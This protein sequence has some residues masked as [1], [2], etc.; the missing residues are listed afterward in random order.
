MGE[1]KMVVMLTGLY[2]E[3]AALKAIADEQKL[4]RRPE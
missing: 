1:E 4:L 2:I 3:L